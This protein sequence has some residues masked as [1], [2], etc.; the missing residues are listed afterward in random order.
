MR[1]EKRERS[2]FVSV[3]V[4]LFIAC[5]TITSVVFLDENDTL[6]EEKSFYVFPTPFSDPNYSTFSELQLYRPD[7]KVSAEGEPVEEAP[8]EV[9]DEKEIRAWVCIHAYQGILLGEGTLLIEE[10]LN[11]QNQGGSEETEV[12]ESGG[13]MTSESSFNSLSEDPNATYSMQAQM[14]NTVTGGGSTAYSTF[15][16]YSGPP[17]KESKERV[18]SLMSKNREESVSFVVDGQVKADDFVVNSDGRSLTLKS[19]VDTVLKL[20][21][22]NA[23]LYRTQLMLE[24]RVKRLEALLR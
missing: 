11:G 8:V 5:F 6:G 14:L 22:E 13:D 21:E 12:T 20:R 15:R 9:V 2:Q 23:K 24:E 4:S 7:V 10:N 19:A 16:Y 3:V 1:R 17:S 18:V